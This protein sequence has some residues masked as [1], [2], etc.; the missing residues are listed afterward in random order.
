MYQ[1]KGT[2]KA[3]AF[4]T[5][6]AANVSSKKVLPWNKETDK[7]YDLSEKDKASAYDY[8]CGRLTLDEHYEQ[9]KLHVPPRELAN[10][11]TNKALVFNYVPR[12]DIP[13]PELVLI[14]HDEDPEG[15]HVFPA[16]VSLDDVEKI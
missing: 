8:T 2:I 4:G 15:D 6:E 3:Y 13:N 9:L 10:L 5:G 16:W 12:I 7:W 11:L 14:Y 1:T